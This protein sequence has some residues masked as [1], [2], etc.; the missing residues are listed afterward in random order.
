MAPR[1]QSWIVLKFGGTSVSSLANWCNIAE[2]LAA[3]L[4]GGPARVLVVHSAVSGITDRL[5]KLLAAALS[6]MHE[7]LL[8]AIEQRH[9]Q[10]AEELG[11]GVSAE[12]QQYFALLK[13]VADGIALTNEVSDRTRARALATGELMATELGARFLN[14]RGIRAS[15]W[16]ARSGLKAA[17]RAHVPAR[18][19]FLSATCEFVPDPALQRQLAL[20]PGVVI[21][22]G[23][24]ASDAAGDTVLL[25]RGGSDTSAA[26]LAAKLAAERLEIWTDV[27]GLFSANP[28]STPQARLLRSLHY[29]EAQEIASSGAKVLHPRCILPAKSQQIPIAVFATQSPKLPG[30]YISADGGD[31]VAQVKAVCIKKGITL[32]SL[33]SPGMWHEVGFLADAFQVF[34]RHGL[35]V[36]LVS[37]SETNVTVSLDPAANTLDAALI[38]RLLADLAGLCR[39]QV[40]GPC[41]SVSLVGRN[42][43]AILHQLGEAFE[44][45]ADQRI[46]LL[47]QAANDLNFSFV[48][49][50]EQGD[51]LVNA[52]HERLIRPV[53]GQSILGPTWQQLFAPPA[54]AAEPAPSWWRV[55]RAQLLSLGAE[56][57][58]AYVYDAQVIRAAAAALT[59][60][61]SIDRVLY[62]MKAN[63]HAGILRLLAEHG[64]GF[65]CVSRGEIEYLRASV[66]QLAPGRVLFTPNFAARDEYAW[67]L[68]QGVTVGIDNLYVLRE[69]GELFRG[70]DIFIRLDTGTG[71]G[72]HQHVRTAGAHAKFGVPIAAAP[73][74]EHLTA[75]HGARVIGLHAHSGSGIFDVHN[76]SEAA[77]QL[78]ALA[79]RFPQLRA[80]DIGGGLG[81]SDG[82]GQPQVDLAQ[83]DGALAAAAQDHPGIALW[84]EP[85][86]YL[87]AAAGVLLARVT[88]TKSKGDIHYVGVAT[89][90]NSLIRPALYGAWHEIVNLTRLDEPATHGVNVVGPICES[91][92]FLGHD[93]LL[94]PSVAGDVLLIANAGAYGH[95]MSSRYNLREPAP[96]FLLP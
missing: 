57:D 20:L 60:L 59:A 82:H 29:D 85:G 58:C 17:Q 94:P 53:R 46:Y 48:V 40:I 35:S 19:H 7:P 31:G 49:D 83:L 5:E 27:P 51:R 8:E 73:E 13:Q 86:R 63:P 42:I 70:H 33:E 66:P 64:L 75:H 89:G 15:W 87:V 50:E 90:M 96:E 92:D 6:G 18:A 4:E 79:P 9:R 61:K 77:A 38:E 74:L 47:S 16:D 55:R 88:Q 44:L 39:A 71:R 80:I 22:Q 25:G 91:A 3:R 69:W 43:R 11:I 81:V 21:T 93:R 26:Y 2:V 65:D 62:A 54:Q 78:L 32:V 67:A 95:A 12:L 14:A 28:R 45:F 41:A 36:D 37:T 52:L 23:F 68:E 84:L 10:L 1:G 30:T 76:W 24:I 56:H 72:H 34:K